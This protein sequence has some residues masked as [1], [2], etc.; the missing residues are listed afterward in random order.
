MPAWQNWPCHEGAWWVFTPG[1]PRPSA[2]DVTCV[3]DG[4]VVVWPCFME[5]EVR[6]SD[7]HEGWL[8]APILETP[9]PLPRGTR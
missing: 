1:D 5:A 9:P 3:V 6:E 2:C 7:P 8:F 4:E